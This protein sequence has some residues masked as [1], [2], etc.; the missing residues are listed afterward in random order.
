MASSAPGN[1]AC[2][3]HVTQKQMRQVENCKKYKDADNGTLSF[4]YCVERGCFVRSDDAVETFKCH[5]QNEKSTGHWSSKEGNVENGTRPKG[6][7]NYV[8]SKALSKYIIEYC[9]KKKTTIKTKAS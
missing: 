8:Y 7:A 1:A 3:I 6:V 4:L 2:I 5:A 9:W